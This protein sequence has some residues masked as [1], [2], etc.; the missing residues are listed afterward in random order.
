MRE[1]SLDVL[2][3][4]LTIDGPGRFAVR[5]TPRRIVVVGDH[6]HALVAR[7]FAPHNQAHHKDLLTYGITLNTFFIDR[8][9]HRF[10]PTLYWRFEELPGGSSLSVIMNTRL[11]PGSLLPLD[12]R[13]GSSTSKEAVQP[14][15]LSETFPSAREGEEL[16]VADV[17]VTCNFLFRDA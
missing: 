8:A 17:L 12:V 7:Q 11:L 2:E 10:N 4:V 13:T 3:P 1:S 15:I 5:R 9:D 16:N 6:E 14:K